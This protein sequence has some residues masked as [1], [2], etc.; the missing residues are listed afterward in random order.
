MKLREGDPSDLRPQD[1]G[2]RLVDKYQKKINFIC[3]SERSEE[4]HTFIE[5]LTLTYKTVKVKI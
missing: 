4:S 5:F 2:Q 3:H 1:D